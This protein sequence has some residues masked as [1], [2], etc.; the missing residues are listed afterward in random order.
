[1]YK[2]NLQMEN[3]FFF[4]KSGIKHL[5]HSAIA[6]TNTVKLMWFLKLLSFIITPI[7]KNMKVIHQRWSSMLYLRFK[8]CTKF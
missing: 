2:E 5:T 8:I 7:H 4:W 1:M 3:L 6:N